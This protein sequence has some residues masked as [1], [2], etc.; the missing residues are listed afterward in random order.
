MTERRLRGQIDQLSL[1]IDNLDMH[2]FRVALHERRAGAARRRYGLV[3]R[4][5]HLGRNP[6]DCGHAGQRERR[7]FQFPDS[8]VSVMRRP[9]GADQAALA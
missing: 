3:A 5:L 9:R 2:R 7:S 1:G 4:R 6:A 8:V